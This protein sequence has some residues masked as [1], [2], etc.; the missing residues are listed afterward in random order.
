MKPTFFKKPTLFALIF[1]IFFLTP[2]TL[3]DVM[4]EF[5]EEP[6]AEFK[7]YEGDNFTASVHL[8]DLNQPT[9]VH[10]YLVGPLGV[11]DVKEYLVES[12]TYPKEGDHTFS[13]NGL[14]DNKF[15]KAGSYE[16]RFKSGGLYQDE[17]SALNHKFK[18]TDPFKV[19]V[20]E[21]SG[22]GSSDG[23]NAEDEANNGKD[24]DDVSGIGFEVES[25]EP[26]CGE[27]R[28][29]GNFYKLYEKL[30][31]G[32]HKVDLKGLIEAAKLKA[33][34][35]EWK[36]YVDSLK[37]GGN[38]DIER[39]IA[40]GQ[41]EV[42][43]SE[44]DYSIFCGEFTDIEPNDPDC[45]AIGYVYSIGAMTGYPDGTFRKQTT[46]LRDQL[47]KVSLKAF[48]LFVENADYCKG[49]D[50]YPDVTV[51]G[52]EADWSA[53]Y[54]CRG[55]EQG[56]ITGYKGGDE[57]GQFIPDRLVNVAEFLALILRNLDETMPSTDSSSYP[58]VPAGQWYSGFFKFANTNSLLDS[59]TVKPTD[60]VSRLGVAKVLYKL[61]LLNKL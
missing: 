18:L 56:M 2:I 9:L 6:Q 36:L 46:L 24:D 50:P 52:P 4:I 11:N 59:V 31:N 51:S 40:S 17:K 29:D 44:T 27:L 61:H 1:S 33:G 48:D 54:V 12:Y 28:V 47:A 60:D 49:K 41:F 37:C 35:H 42:E 7:V 15:L 21:D 30:E 16:L 43:G 20:N 38:A 25:T 55:T 19:T 26:I 14:I 45:P 39:E 10:M 58:G 22:T 32:E 53:Q 5:N 13:W 8:S 3:A 57:A 23:E 34:P